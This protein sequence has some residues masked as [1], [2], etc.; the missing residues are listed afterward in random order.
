MTI[1]ERIF[2]MSTYV[3]EDYSNG[4][5]ETQFDNFFK[6]VCYA[7][8]CE[9]ACVSTPGGDYVWFKADENFNT[10]EKAAM[11][12]VRQQHLSRQNPSGGKK[13]KK[14]ARQARRIKTDVYTGSL[15]F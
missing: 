15:P 4:M 3:V 12:L 7:E 10:P 13:A 5:Q 8:Q 6:A 9:E 2:A 14:Q 1:I 11:E